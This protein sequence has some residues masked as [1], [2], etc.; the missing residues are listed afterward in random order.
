MACLFVP[1][2]LKGQDTPVDRE[3]LEALRR[4]RLAQPLLSKAFDLLA[5]RDWEGAKRQFSRCLEASPENPNACFGMADIFSQTGDVPQA[6]G[7]IEKAEKASLDLQQVWETQKT[8][9][10]KLSQSERTSLLR[11]AEDLLNDGMSFYSCNATKI[12]HESNQAA[13]KA[14][15]ITVK[16][17]A[18]DSPFA[19]PAEFY[20]LHGNLL[21]KL[22]RFD[23][24]E[25]RYLQAL[26]IAPAHERCLNNLINIYFISRKFELAQSWLGKA[27]QQKVKINPGLVQAVRRAAAGEKPENR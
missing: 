25:A 2:L 6:L 24:A 13:E 26:A 9:L 7:W 20:S 4:L 17:A 23:E 21:F 27:I 16:G 19:V 3:G 5:A 1:I 15:T 22:K 18:G 14:R 8:S 11:L 12:S 10:F